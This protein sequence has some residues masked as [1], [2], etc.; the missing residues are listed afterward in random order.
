[1][2]GENPHFL[3][4]RNIARIFGL[5][6]LEAILTDHWGVFL[7]HPE[8][9]DVLQ[10]RIITLVEKALSE[11]SDFPSTVRAMR[12][13]SIVMRRHV[14]V[15]TLECESILRTLLH[16]LEP[17]SAS[18]RRVLSME[19]WK[20]IYAEPGLL[21]DFYARFD[22]QEGREHIVHEHLTA[23]AR[24]SAERPDVIGL[25]EQ[26]RVFPTDGASKDQLNE[27]AVMEAGGLAGMIGG[28]ISSNNEELQGIS[29]QWCSPRVP[30]IDQLDK[31]DPPAIPDA[32]IYSLT[33]MCMSSLSDGLAKLILPL[34]IPNN[35]RKQK[36]SKGNDDEG[37]P[38]RRSDV[39]QH[40]AV[41]E[42]RSSGKYSS[43]RAAAPINPLTL[44][45]HP[46]YE[47]VKSAAAMLDECW[48]AVLATCSTF[49]YA[50][51]D[52]TF[53]HSLVRCFQKISHVAG[54]LRLEIPRDAFLTTLSKSAVPPHKSLF[55]APTTPLAQGPKGGNRK[56][57]VKDAW[58][59]L[60]PVPQTPMTPS[61]EAREPVMNLTTSALNTRN[62]L[63]LRALLNL[64]IALGPVLGNAWPTILETWQ[65]A[66]FTL[67]TSF[68]DV[69][70]QKSETGLGP[71]TQTSNQGD[72]LSSEV[73]SEIAAVDAAASRLLES[74]AELSYEAFVD[75][76]H[77]L[78]KLLG[79]ASQSNNNAASLLSSPKTIPPLPSPTNSSQKIYSNYGDTA[80]QMQLAH[81]FLRTIAELARINLSRLT[82]REPDVSGWALLT[83]QLN[84][85]TCSRWCNASIRLRSAEVLNTLVKEAAI[86]VT[87]ESKDLCNSVVVRSI[88]TLHAEIY[89]LTEDVEDRSGSTVKA[90]IEIHKLALD[91]LTIILENCGEALV[92]GW[93]TVFEIIN[94]IF[95]MASAAPEDE[96]RG[97][98]TSRLNAMPSSTLKASKLIRPAFTSLQLICSDFLSSIPNSCILVLIDTLSRYCSQYDDLNI[99]LTVRGDLRILSEADL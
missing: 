24:I 17:Y 50:T 79:F 96:T 27:Q 55:R 97:V 49:L 15:L 91:S 22:G 14:A 19:V 30:C 45:Q 2:E 86:S 84:S 6:L 69:K 26:S 70:S 16:L 93:E 67:H 77:A 23:L 94:S 12:L 5:E 47:K 66:D 4:V 58:P 11:Q 21:E 52:H 43:R 92:A 75:V 81:F 46:S 3:H 44:R 65:Q 41:E 73:E 76:L 31:T 8:Q 80:S 51:L 13:V 32:Y 71:T 35:G 36:R 28:V 90:D 9:T 89:R 42:K 95:N 82:G 56:S 7:S 29:L 60:T 88:E 98:A 99:S 38:S 74:T 57:D 48:P 33:L 78:G 18:W 59:A 54:L 72:G 25:G 37:S 87:G 85:L 64:G 62:L 34:T 1:M 61:D 53:F 68:R 20:G 63:C 39:P 40:K 10:S 83:G